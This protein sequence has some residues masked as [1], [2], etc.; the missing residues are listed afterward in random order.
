MQ[1]NTI[2]GQQEGQQQEVNYDTVEQELSKLKDVFEEFRSDVQ[3]TGTFFDPE[4][5]YVMEDD[6]SETGNVLDAYREAL[7]ERNQDAIK[8]YFGNDD[9]IQAVIDVLE[10]GSFSRQVLLAYCKL[11][12]NTPWNTAQ[13]NISIIQSYKN[14]NFPD[15]N[16]TSNVLKRLNE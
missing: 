16:I 9:R 11:D 5:G 10:P 6:E 15:Y 1:V 13:N 7:I 8:S 4:K 12:E 3:N 2:E 14:E